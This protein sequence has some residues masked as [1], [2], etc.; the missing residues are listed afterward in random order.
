FQRLFSYLFIG[1]FAAL[2]NLG[3]FWVMLYRITLPVD[4]RLHYLIAN[5]VA[6]EISI[7]A[8]FIPN[9]RI[10]FSHLPGHSRSWWARCGRF[11][12]TAIGG[13]TVTAI[14]SIAL[15]AA[16]APSIIA[17]ASA[18]LLALAFNFTFHHLFTYRHI[19]HPTK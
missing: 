1:G 19:P 10:T 13:T 2:V 11:H 18:I 3:V 16:G 8:N 4:A 5:L 6:A 7:F 15:H 17:Q 12:I 9:D 14:V